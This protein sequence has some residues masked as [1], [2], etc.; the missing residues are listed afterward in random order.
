VSDKSCQ[1][2][3]IDTELRGHPTSPLNTLLINKIRK[4]Y[5]ECKM[6]HSAPH[7]RAQ[8]IVGKNYIQFQRAQ[9]AMA[10]TL[11]KFNA[12]KVRAKDV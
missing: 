12:C 5:V 2:S 1:D 9:G 8:V 10:T 6:I 4:A 3:L 11:S 7:H